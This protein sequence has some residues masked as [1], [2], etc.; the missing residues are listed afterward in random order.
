MLFG[1]AASH[2]A[3]ASADEDDTAARFDGRDVF[4]TGVDPAA[5]LRDFGNLGN[6][7]RSAF[8]IDSDVK[9]TARLAVFDFASVDVAS[10]LEGFGDS[11]FAL[12]HKGGHHYD[13]NSA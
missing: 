5:R 3:F 8:G 13:I 10:V 6:T 9:R 1:F 11:D 7:G 4:N 12:E 2:D